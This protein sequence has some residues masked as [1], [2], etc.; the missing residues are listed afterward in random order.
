MNQ[1]SLERSPWF[2]FQDSEDI[3]TQRNS[4][5]CFIRT[6]RIL[7]HAFSNK[8]IIS[9]HIEQF[10][11]NRVPISQTRIV[12]NVMNQLDLSAFYGST[13]HVTNRARVCEPNIWLWNT[14]TLCQLKAGRDFESNLYEIAPSLITPLSDRSMLFVNVMGLWYFCANIISFQHSNRSNWYEYHVKWST[15]AAAAK[16]I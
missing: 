15:R 3:R 7:K 4:M 2:Q 8:C 12:E 13:E 16:R 6:Q 11:S 5:V 10:A 1:R 14:D 9:R